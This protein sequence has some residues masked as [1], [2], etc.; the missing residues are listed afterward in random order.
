MILDKRFKSFYFRKECGV[1]GLRSF[2]QF[3]EPLPPPS[4][5]S[6]SFFVFMLQ[7]L[8][9]LLIIKILSFRALHL[10]ISIDYA[11]DM[12]RAI[13]SKANQ[14]ESFF[15]CVQRLCSEII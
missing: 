2:A 10:Y 7:A 13:R 12:L 15:S 4:S 5:G 1:D 14:F 6:K 8:E 3:S 9:T 11:P